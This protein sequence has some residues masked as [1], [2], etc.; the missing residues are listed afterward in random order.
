M[1]EK[2]MILIGQKK[3][4]SYWKTFTFSASFCSR[5]AESIPKSIRSTFLSG[6]ELF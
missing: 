5:F 2:I 1:S 4:K 3:K 6:A